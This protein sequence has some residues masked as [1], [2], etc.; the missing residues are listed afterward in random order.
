MLP[1]RRTRGSIG[2]AVL[3]IFLS[4]LCLPCFAAEPPAQP[5]RPR[6]AVLVVFDQLRGDYLQRWDGLFGKDGFRRLMTEGAWF[7]NCHYPYANTF[8]AAGHTS[9]VTGG[10][11]RQHGLIANEWYDRAGGAVTNCVRTDRYGPVPPVGEKKDPKNP[12]L[13]AA[14]LR[15]L[16]PTLGDALKEATGGKGRVVSLS[17]KDRAAVLMAGKKPDACYWF[18]TN[19]GAFVTSTYYRDRLHP[20]VAAFNGERPADRWYGRDWTRLRPDLDY[21]RFSG[22]DDVAAEANLYGEGRTFPHPLTG[23]KAKLGRDYYQA[24]TNSP[25]GNDL[26]LALAKRAI[27][28]ERLGANDVP[29]LLCLSF[30]CNDI[31]GHCFGPDSQEVLD[32]TLRSDL[33]VKELLAHLDAKVGKGRYLLAVSADHGICPL[34]EVARAQGKDAGRLSPTLLTSRADAF[35]NET[36]NKDGEAVRWVEAATYPW[37]YLNHGVVKERGVELGKVE[38]ALAGWLRKQPGIQAAYTGTRLAQGPF[39][40][41]PVGERVRQS[42]YPG[43]SG[44]V[45]VVTKP[46]YLVTSA[47]VGTFHGTPHEYDTH[48]PLLIYGPGIRPGVFSEAVTPQA[49]A[50][51]LAH[52]L[53]I[54]PPAGA[55]APVPASLKKE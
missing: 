12:I 7:Q 1:R 36:F 47:L 3:A 23:G 40:D 13:G 27:D 4:L 6:L 10:S 26:L 15:V 44:D 9:L 48:V 24:V 22:P 34:P 46:Y 5:A 43:R 25:F 18:S 32:V 38:E 42:H 16:L 31:I 45:T 54:K 49:M 29:D 11:P 20:W 14:P 51:V 53:G 39:K 17:L 35:L 28:A 50:A 41:D 30:S 37:V 19:A 21:A 2:P 8:T 33:I 55:Q 52:G